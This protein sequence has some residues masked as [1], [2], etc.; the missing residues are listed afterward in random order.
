MKKIIVTGG[1]F[2]GVQAAIELS[3][4]KIFDVT[5]ISDRDYFFLYP[6]S[7]WIPTK[8]IPFEKVKVP[9]SKISDAH[10]FKII[11]D[12]LTKVVSEQNKIEFKTQTMEYDYLILAVGADKVQHTGIQNTLSICGK[13]EVSLEIQKRI[14]ELVKRKKGTI[15]LGFGGNPKDKSAVRGGPAFELAFNLDHHLRKNGIRDKFNLIFFAPMEEPGARMGLKAMKMANIMLDSKGIRRHYGKK[16]KKFETDGIVFEDDS[17][18][19][20]DLTLFIPASAGNKAL[21]N[22][23]LPL[24]EA[25]FVKIDDTC[26]VESTKNVFAVGDVAA[27]SGPEWKA[28]Q[29]HMAEVMARAAANNIYAI[30]TNN[31]ERTGYQKHLNILCIMDTGNGAAFVFRNDK[32]AFA[33]P[34]PLVG[35]SI[36]KMWGKYSTFVKLGKI[37]RFPGM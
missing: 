26:L 23:D 33:I 25:G 18:I 19:E 12:E 35:H 9:L 11:V 31:S 6:I 32:R 13:P 2:A 36:K 3:K 21:Q 5:L 1:G 34:L 20:S 10:G 27:L 16:I 14:E 4:K 24:D 28:K 29:G 22:S 30:E 15:A 8:E 37:P 7:I 17:K